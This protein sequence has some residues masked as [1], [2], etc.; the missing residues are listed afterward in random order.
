MFVNCNS[1][2]NVLICLFWTG[3][4]NLTLQL[5]L[6]LEKVVQVWLQAW[7]IAAGVSLW[8]I[9]IT[10]TLTL[11]DGLYRKK[12]LILFRE[13]GSDK[14]II[15]MKSRKYLLQGKKLAICLKKTK[16]CTSCNAQYKI[17]IAPHHK[18]YFILK[19]I[20]K[21]F[22]CAYVHTAVVKSTPKYK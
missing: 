4:V 2:S 19:Q 5:T 11:L 20:I 7:A 3:S 13:I 12:S 1:N 8:D 22:K 18:R 6:N 14:R 15:Q 9:L 21:Y 16:F 10:T 17:T